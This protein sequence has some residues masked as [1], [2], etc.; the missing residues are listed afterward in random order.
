MV[1]T[2]TKSSPPTWDGRACKSCC[3]MT[4]VYWQSTPGKKH[5]VVVGKVRKSTNRK[6]VFNFH[7]ANSWPCTHGEIKTLHVWILSFKF[8]HLNSNDSKSNPHFEFSIKTLTLTC[9]TEHTQSSGYRL[10]WLQVNIFSLST[11]T[12]MF[13]NKQFLLQ[14]QPAWTPLIKISGNLSH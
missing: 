4:E 7:S 6:N 12:N 2:Q 8:K 11:E 14:V 13:T 9:F 1:Q 3:Q 5:I 10:L